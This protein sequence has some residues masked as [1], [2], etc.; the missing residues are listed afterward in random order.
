MQKEAFYSK[1][2]TLTIRDETEWPETIFL[3]WNRLVQPVH[4]KIYKYA[5]KYIHIRGK[6]TEIYG[7]GSSSKKI[8]KQLKK[9]LKICQNKY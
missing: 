8:I 4:L 3:N 1:T 2:Q 5:L 7:D 9:L 6:R